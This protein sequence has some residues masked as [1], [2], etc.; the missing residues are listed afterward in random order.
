MKCTSTAQDPDPHGPGIQPLPAPCQGLSSLA[1]QQ[2]PSTWTA[3]SHHRLSRCSFGLVRPWITPLVANLQH[4]G[5]HQWPQPYLHQQESNLT[6]G[7]RRERHALTFCPRSAKDLVA[8]VTTAPQPSSLSQLALAPSRSPP[9]Q[10]AGNH[11]WKHAVAAHTGATEAATEEVMTTAS[12]TAQIRLE[13]DCTSRE[14]RWYLPGQRAVDVRV[15][16]P[17][18]G[19]ELHRCRLLASR[20]PA[21]PGTAVLV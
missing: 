5:H 12:L 6:F 17:V 8:A 14:R 10:S 9:R 16:R 18:S 21:S 11:R 2:A 4:E 3:A 15:R 7:I 13:Q 19:T 20:S 1:A